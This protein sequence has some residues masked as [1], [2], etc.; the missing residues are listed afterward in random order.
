MPKAMF[1]PVHLATEDGLIAVGGVLNETTLTEAY[2]RGIFPWPVSVEFPMA[3]FSPDPRG[4]VIFDHFHIPTSFK[5]FLKKN[6]YSILYNQD[7]SQVIRLCASVKRKDQP[8]TWITPEII[9]A[10]EDFHALGKAYCVGVYDKEELVGGLYGVCI[11]EFFS[12]ESMFSLKDNASK[13]A[14][15]SLIHTLRGQGIHF[16]DTQMVTP[17]VELFGGE[18]V[19]RENFIEII[20]KLDW[21]KPI[22]LKA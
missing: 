3:W 22:S 11:G 12:G 9:K 15:Y 16:L 13:F 10:Y 8:S 19:A 18:Y 20:S 4:L 6:T 7:F 1:P 5:K 14:L 2:R 17:V 21:E